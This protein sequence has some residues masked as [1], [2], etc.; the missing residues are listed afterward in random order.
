M[1]EANRWIRKVVPFLAIPGILACLWVRLAYPSMIPFINDEPLFQLIV[2]DHLAKGTIPLVAMRGSSIPLAYGA[3]AMWIY[4][5]L[6][7]FFS[8]LEGLAFFHALVYTLGLAAIG[9]VLWRRVERPL[10]WLFLWLALSSPWLFFFSRMLWDN[11]FFVFLSACLL[12]ALDHLDRKNSQAPFAW[13]VLVFVAALMINIHPMAGPVVL[14]GGLT[15]TIV[16]WRSSASRGRKIVLL[17]SALLGFVV[18]VAPYVWEAIYLYRHEGLVERDPSRKPWGDGRN[19]WWLLQRSFVFLSF[20]KSENQFGLVF[21]DFLKFVGFPWDKL[22]WRDVLA[23]VPKAVAMAYVFALPFRAWRGKRLDALQW[24][25]FLAFVIGILVFNFLNIP[26]EAHYFHAVWWLGFL[27]LAFALEDLRPRWK[28]VLIPW[29]VVCAFLN[30]AFIV[31]SNRFI[32]ANEGMRN[33]TY[34]STMREVR[35]RIAEVCLASPVSHVAIYTRDVLLLGFPI[36]YFNRHLPECAG[37]EISVVE[38][39]ELAQWRLKY[40]DGPQATSAFLVWEKIGTE[41]R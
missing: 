19:L 39:P 33:L 11:T 30:T 29:V 35:A 15:A 40:R 41:E 36:R 23:W 31:Q 9:L 32:V 14:A 20:W 22:L 8:S 37:R 24:V 16:V 7:W 12:L 13:I 18:L 25:T 38:A 5:I 6:R 27:A 26:T 17:S 2:D 1:E 4:G 3:G 34:A 10:V 28:T 21:P